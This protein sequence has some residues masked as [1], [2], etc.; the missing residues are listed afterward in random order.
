MKNKK[1]SKKTRNQI[2]DFGFL[3]IKNF[4]DLTGSGRVVTV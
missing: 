1:I 3:H 4:K 2:H